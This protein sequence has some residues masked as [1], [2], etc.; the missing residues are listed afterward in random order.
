MIESYSLSDV[1]AT[2]SLAASVGSQLVAGDLVWLR[3]ELGAGKTTF[4]QELARSLGVEEDV[5]SPTFVL[6]LEYKSGRVP[7][8]HCDAYRL[9][10]LAREEL[11][12]AGLFDFLARVDAVRLLEWP[13]RIALHLPPPTWNIEIA[14]ENDGRR[15]TV[16]RAEKS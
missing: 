12:D 10:N 3:G 5:T 11:E 1:C 15:A 16:W 13:E 6:M 4:A 14:F 9:E 8:L 2:R 7:L